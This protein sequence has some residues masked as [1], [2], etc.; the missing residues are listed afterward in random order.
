MHGKK[1]FKLVIYNVIN[2]ATVID[3]IDYRPTIHLARIAL[4]YLC[5]PSLECSK[6][7]TNRENKN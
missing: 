3:E 5:S 7:N 2:D 1:S 6:Q 4:H